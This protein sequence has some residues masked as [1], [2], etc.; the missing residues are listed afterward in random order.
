M[1]NFLM[2]KERLMKHKK[3]ENDNKIV[4]FCRMKKTV[5]LIVIIFTLIAGNS[6]AQIAIEQLSSNLLRR[7]VMQSDLHFERQCIEKK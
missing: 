2:T 5:S 3:T 6:S 7:M 1:L 4:Y